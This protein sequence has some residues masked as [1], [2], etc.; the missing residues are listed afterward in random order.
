MKVYFI[1]NFN[2]I[3][4]FTQRLRKIYLTRIFCFFL[5]NLFLNLNIAQVLLVLKICYID[6]TRKNI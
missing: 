3:I 2:F 4:Y 6:I 1:F 5:D